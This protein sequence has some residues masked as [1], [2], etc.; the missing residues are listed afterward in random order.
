MPGKWD[1]NLK[2]L[3]NAKPEHFIQWFFPEA[4]FQGKIEKK[5][6]NLETRQLEVDG[7]L[8]FGLYG[9]ACL[10]HIEFHSYYDENMARRMWEYNALASIMYGRPTYSV[11]IYLKECRVTDPY[12]EEKMPTGEINHPFHF[13]VIKLWELHPQDIK[14]MKDALKES[15]AYQFIL[16][17]GREEGLQEGRE[18]E[19][20][21]EVQRLRQMLASYVELHFPTVVDEA[22]K[23]AEMVQDPDVLQQVTLKIFAAQ[24]NE[25]MLEILHEAA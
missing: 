7:L 6:N 22:R 1:T 12:Y 19:R 9:I 13:R 10:L 3:L 14:D 23:Y 17:E 11:L 5:S 24:T 16:Q 21:Q 4:T 25:Q 20:R 2:L 18:E 15:W 8:P